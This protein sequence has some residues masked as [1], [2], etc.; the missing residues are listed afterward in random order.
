MSILTDVAEF[1]HD[2][3]VEGCPVDPIIYIV[4]SDPDVVRSI[5]W[6]LDGIDLN[7]RKCHD[8]QSFLDNY[9]QKHPG[10]VIMDVD[11]PDLSMQRGLII[12]GINNA[13]SES[14]QSIQLIFWSSRGDVPTLVK[15]ILGESVPVLEE[16]DGYD[17]L[18]DVVRLAARNAVKAFHR[19][20]E[21]R[22]VTCQI[23]NLTSRERDVLR[24]AVEGLP[25]KSIARTLGTSVKT[26]D[27]HRHHIKCKTESGNISSLVRDVLRYDINV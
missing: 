12:G 19:Q 6:T 18:F 5:S 8:A 23:A 4:H 15:A 3:P 9:D 17:A 14:T 10:C 2:K 21:I 24:L 26:I 13:V 22:S 25:S 7:I 11:L 20:H 27:V 16:P 1:T